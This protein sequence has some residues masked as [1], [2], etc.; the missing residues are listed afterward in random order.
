M[1]QSQMAEPPRVRPAGWSDP[2]GTRPYLGAMLL[3][4]Y[5]DDGKLIYAGGRGEPFPIDLVEA[6]SA[7]NL[8]AQLTGGLLPRL[9]RSLML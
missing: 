6:H 2:E 8:E 9:M 1:A 3:G 4:Y 7:C 5:T